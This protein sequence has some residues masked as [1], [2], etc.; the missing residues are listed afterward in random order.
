[1]TH[2]PARNKSQTPRQNPKTLSLPTPFEA[3]YPNITAWVSNGGWIEIGDEIQT[4]SFIRALDDGGMIWEGA[5]RYKSVDE[6]LQA[7]ERGIA[8]WTDENY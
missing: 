3:S 4:G 7:L 5:K 8:K 2:K 1:M 6:A